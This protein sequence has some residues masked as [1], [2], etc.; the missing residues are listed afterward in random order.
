MNEETKR[1]MTKTYFKK[2]PTWAL[3][4]IVVGLIACSAGGGGIAFGLLLLAAGG[5]AIYFSMGGKPSDQQMDE[6]LDEDFEGSR[7]QGAEQDGN[8]R[9]RMRE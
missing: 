5:A 7:A 4:A 8:R 1:R 9:V 3:G 6:W 2:F